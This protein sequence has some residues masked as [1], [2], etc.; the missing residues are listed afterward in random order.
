[1]FCLLRDGMRWQ[2]DLAA[3]RRA[4]S[5][6]VEPRSACCAA[7]VAAISSEQDLAEG[8]AEV[9]IED[10]V[11]DGVQKTV[12]VA[13]PADDAD[14]QVGVVAAVATKRSNKCQDKERKPAADERPG[15]DA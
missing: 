14:Q 9:G 10:R 1:M 7:G 15:D 8:E 3:T 6:I 5:A 12:E 11:D 13:E 4:G 2:A